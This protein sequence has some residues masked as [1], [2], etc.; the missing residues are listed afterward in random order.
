M[1]HGLV[2]LSRQIC[3]S[4]TMVRVVGDVVDDGWTGLILAGLLRY[5]WYWSVASLRNM[6]LMNTLM[7]VD[8]EI[9]V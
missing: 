8:L 6:D 7:E 5:L 4:S 1:Y 2:G 9:T 3:R